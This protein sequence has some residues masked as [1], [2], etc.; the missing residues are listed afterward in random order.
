MYGLIVLS[1]ITFSVETIPNLGDSVV[2]VLRWT[3]IAIVLIFT[4]E[5]VTRVWLATQKSR[6]VFSFFGIVDL[7]S[8]VPFYLGLAVDLRSM[9]I[10]R[11]FRLFRTLKFLRGERAVLLLATAYRN[12]KA[13]IFIVLVATLIVLYIAAV[14]IYYFENEAQPDAFKSVFHSLWWAVAT[15]TTVGYGDVYPV[16]LGGRL[17]TFIVLIV[18]LGV[19]ALPAAVFS[20]A[21]TSARQEIG[22]A[23]CDSAEAGDK[24]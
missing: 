15:L 19:V 6:Y 7:L 2:R 16:T 11:L 17:F 22:R 3:E 10:L 9:R 20:S 12:A 18:G 5:Y 13:E 14:G 21:L 8:I 4:V 23:K 24:D 1:L